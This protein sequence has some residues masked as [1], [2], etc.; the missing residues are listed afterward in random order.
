MLGYLMGSLSPQSRILKT[1]MSV[2]RAVIG[3]PSDFQ[4]IYLWHL[5]NSFLWFANIALKPSRLRGARVI[6]RQIPFLGDILVGHFELFG[7]W[8][9]VLKLTIVIF[10]LLRRSHLLVH[11]WLFAL[12]CSLTLIHFRPHAANGRSLETVIQFAIAIFTLTTMCAWLSLVFFS[13]SINFV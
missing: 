10:S 13:N 8:F 9:R 5:V 12:S 6:N 4:S 2:V 1:S 7:I 3:P 11:R